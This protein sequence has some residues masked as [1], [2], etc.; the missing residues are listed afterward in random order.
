MFGKIL[1]HNGYTRR[2]QRGEWWCY[3]DRKIAKSALFKRRKI[4]DKGGTA[5]TRWIRFVYRSRAALFRRGALFFCV[6][7]HTAKK[8]LVV[9]GLRGTETPLARD[10][11]SLFYSLRLRTGETGKERR[12]TSVTGFSFLSPSRFSWVRTCNGRRYDITNSECGRH[13]TIISQLRRKF[14]RKFFCSE[15]LAD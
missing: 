13:R 1:F 12:Q 10:M 9:P 3:T 8:L 7:C 2:G 4:V 5:N 11:W 14:Q 6:F 15:N